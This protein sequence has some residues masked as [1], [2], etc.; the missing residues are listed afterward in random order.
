VSKNSAEIVTET[1]NGFGLG[2]CNFA[3][4]KNRRY[5]I[6]D[7]TFRYSG[8]PIEEPIEPK[9]CGTRSLSAIEKLSPEEL[10]LLPLLFRS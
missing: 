4:H 9:S 3:D 2:G 7:Y 10:F 1:A 5:Q 6:D 8:V